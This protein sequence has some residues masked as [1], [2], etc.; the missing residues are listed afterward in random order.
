MADLCPAGCTGC[1]ARCRLV[2]QRAKPVIWPAIFNTTL[3]MPFVSG[4][5]GRRPPDWWRR[6]PNFKTM[7]T[8]R[9]DD[10]AA[11]G[12]LSGP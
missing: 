4:F 3:E 1:H 7:R 11:R 9:D 8:L 2:Q 12:Q 6:R 5:A 10:G